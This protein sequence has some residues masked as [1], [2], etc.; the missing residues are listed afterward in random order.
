MQCAMRIV[1]SRRILEGEE[2]PKRS[3][4]DVSSTAL[5]ETR[6]K[7]FREKAPVKDPQHEG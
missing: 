1:I 5:T 4:L 3:P 2:R 7:E 6:Y